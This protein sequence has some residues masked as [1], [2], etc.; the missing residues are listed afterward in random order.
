MAKL[1]R[2]TTVPMSLKV[3]LRGQMKFMQEAGF[4]VIMVSADGK[5]LQDVLEYE[6]CPHKL[7]EMTRQITPLQDLTAIW[8]LYKFF[9]SE[10]PDIVHS[11]TPKAGLL[12]MLAAKMAGVKIRIHTIAG[13][14][15][16][17]SSGVT[18]SLLVRMEKVTGHAATHV[19]PNSHSLLKYVQDNNLVPAKKMEVIGKGSSNGI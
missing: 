19:W 18:R 14:R 4:Q 3:L 13:L 1:I 7:I 11:H 5:E 17:T 8:K 12:A 9:K 10:K 16:M 15:F 6:K 2:V